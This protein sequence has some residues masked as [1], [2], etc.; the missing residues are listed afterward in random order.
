[1]GNHEYC[2][3]CEQNDFHH[4]R[5]CD[6]KDLAE[7]AQRKAMSEAK[8]TGRDLR[9]LAQDWLAK[10]ALMCHGWMLADLTKLLESVAPSPAPAQPAPPQCAYW[11][12]EGTVQCIG[13]A[14]PNSKWCADHK[15]MDDPKR[16]SS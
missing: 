3:E 14:L 5:P 4:G 10:N 7:I 1:M 9:S 16:A 11:R 13:R 6:P 8:G 15:Y 2:P 12:Y